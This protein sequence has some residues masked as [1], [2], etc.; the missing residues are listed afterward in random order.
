MLPSILV[1]DAPPKT[2][3]EVL[4]GERVRSLREQRGWSQDELAA[5]MKDLGFNW[6]QSTAAKTE[7][8]HRPIRVDEATALASLLDVELNDLV[9]P[10][11]HPLITRIQELANVRHSLES[12]VEAQR[13]E[14]RQKEDAIAQT[15]EMQEYVT[16][17][18]R[19][20]APFLENMLG[21]TEQVSEE[22]VRELVR[23]FSLDGAWSDILDEFAADD[24]LRQVAEDEAEKGHVGDG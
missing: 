3:P 18:L 19:A 22:N 9:R 4:L 1:E 2:R 20:L 12:K 21:D 17:K 8:A 16:A 5:R 11:V 13:S 14:L 23:R 7:K 6:L 24:H 10:T 15:L